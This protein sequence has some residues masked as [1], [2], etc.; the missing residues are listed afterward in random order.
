MKALPELSKYND[1][2]ISNADKG[3]AEDIHDVKDSI[4]EAE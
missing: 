4:K 3:G 2:I 1:I